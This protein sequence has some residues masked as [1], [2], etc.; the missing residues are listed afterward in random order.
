MAESPDRCPLP[1]VN[2]AG[3]TRVDG[4]AYPERVNLRAL[5]QRSRGGNR[6]TGHRRDRLH[7]AIEWGRYDQLASSANGIRRSASESFAGSRQRG[8]CDLM[9]CACFFDAPDA[10]RSVLQQLFEALQPLGFELSFARDG[11]SCLEL[12]RREPSASRSHA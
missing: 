5:Q 12:A 1:V 6:L 10:G 8:H 7:D 3:I 11:Q 4:Y 9:L 2:G